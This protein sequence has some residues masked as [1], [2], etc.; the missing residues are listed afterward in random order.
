M[1]KI[2]CSQCRRTL[3]VHESGG[4]TIRITCP[5]CRTVNRVDLDKKAAVAG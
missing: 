1:T 5:R 4:G 3:A 2:T